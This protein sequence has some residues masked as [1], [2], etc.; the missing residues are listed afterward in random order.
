[1]GVRACTEKHARILL[2]PD[3]IQS[4][5]VRTV[6]EDIV[7]PAW[8]II[9][10]VRSEGWKGPVHRATTPMTNPSVLVSSLRAKD[11]KGFPK[12]EK[13]GILISEQF[14]SC[15]EFARLLFLG[16]VWGVPAQRHK[17]RSNL[18]KDGIPREWLEAGVFWTCAIPQ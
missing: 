8:D 11:L 12:A 6:C 3:N 5:N 4:S 9:S 15:A 13:Y 16:H 14:A 7:R 10:A 18:T 2:L 17:C 1:M